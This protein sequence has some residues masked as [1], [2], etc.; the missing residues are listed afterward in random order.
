MESTGAGSNDLYK[1]LFPPT[2]TIEN[3]SSTYIAESRQRATGTH[4][5]LTIL[6]SPIH[7]SKRITG[8]HSIFYS[9]SFYFHNSCHININKS[10]E[11][12]S[13]SVPL[14]IFILLF[15]LALS[16]NK[17]SRK[18]RCFLL[19]AFVIHNK[20]IS[21]SLA[22]VQ[23]RMRREARVRAI[24]EAVEHNGGLVECE[25]ARKYGFIEI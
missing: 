1:C 9:I 21:I 5:P 22:V 25:L 14:L 17:I 13:S 23:I 20:T 7:N 10:Y 15:Y 11:N 18:V 2:T 12:T 19:F 24:L 3:R 8:T 6:L 16:L 4:T